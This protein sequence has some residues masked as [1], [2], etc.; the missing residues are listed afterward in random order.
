MDEDCKHG[1]N[2]HR[3]QPEEL[4]AYRDKDNSFYYF[5]PI[6]KEWKTTEVSPSG[7]TAPKDSEPAKSL[8]PSVR[9]KS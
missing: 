1:N 4:S 6:A 8:S 3:H 7:I 5:D 2:R 9:G